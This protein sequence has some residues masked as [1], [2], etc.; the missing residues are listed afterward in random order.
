MPAQTHF[1]GS[2]PSSR[3]NLRRVHLG[4][5]KTHAC[6]YKLRVGLGL[7]FPVLFFVPLF[8][9]RLSPRTMVNILGSGFL[10]IHAKYLSL[11]PYSFPVSFRSSP[12]RTVMRFASTSSKVCRSLPS[13][14]RF[15]SNSITVVC[16]RGA[17]G[18]RVRVSIP[19]V[20]FFIWFRSDTS[21]YCGIGSSFV[22]VRLLL[23]F[24]PLSSLGLRF[25]IMKDCVSGHWLGEGFL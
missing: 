1:V 9:R 10:S 13:P 24:C 21:W 4:T 11:I 25:W 20:R 8:L 5:W 23:L 17:P 15:R 22:F 16:A 18:S 3:T 19:K 6:H 12:R 14:N 7:S 2:L